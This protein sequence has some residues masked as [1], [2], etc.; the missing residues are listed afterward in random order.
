MKRIALFA[1]LVFAFLTANGQQDAQFSQYIFNGIYINP[2]YAGYKQDMYLHSF[3]RSQ[4]T[5]LNG[6]PQTYA[7][8][9]D[10]A[11]NDGTVGLGLLLSHDQI[12]AQS[13]TAAY[14]NAAYRIE[15]GK[16]GE[17]SWLAFGIG[18]GILQSGLDGTKLYAAQAGDSNVPLGFQSAILP[19]ARI[20]VLYTTDHFF[21]GA[22]IDNLL[23]QYM[24]ITTSDQSLTVVIPKPH[25][26]FTV[27]ALFAL[28]D[29]TKIKPSILIKD[30]Q[31]APTSID[32]NAFVLLN[33]KLWLGGTYRTG[34]SVFKKNL[35][36]GLSSSSALV[37]MAEFFVNKDLRIG[38]AFDYSL[39][40][41]GSYG[42]GSHELSIGFSIK[43]KRNDVSR[44]CYF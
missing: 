24:H 19:D 6:A 2:A 39:N 27:G 44:T 28:N 26:Y 3:A 17:T 9:G 41:L 32:L 7:V 29:E 43:S 21:A 30:T 33:D 37:A 35:P 12:G 23:P 38:Y 18:F 1:S 11:V 14:G 4:W 36:A 13:T 20:G 22:S 8:A 42:Y 16:T 40:K 15:L 31:G 10:V 34:L 25:R 5:G